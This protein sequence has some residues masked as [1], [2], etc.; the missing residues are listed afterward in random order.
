MTGNGN[1]VR[2]VT[3]RIDVGNM[4]AHILDAGRKHAV[5][6]VSMPR[7]ASTP[8]VDVDRLAVVLAHAA[9]VW[10]LPTGDLSW[11][12]TGRLPPG[13]DVYGGATRVWWPGMSAASDP[14]EQPLLLAHDRS[15]GE[16]VVA[17]VVSLFR[18]R[19]L[20]A[21][22][23]D[24][25]AD[26]GAET[27]AVVSAIRP[28]GAELTLADGRPA[29][30]ATR[31]LCDA[32]LSADR[33]V[34]VGQ[35]VRVVVRG[36]RMDD[37]RIQVTLRPFQPDPWAR[38]AEEY[39]PGMLI[40][41]IVDELRRAGAFVTLL[42]G[43]RGLLRRSQL[44][45]EWV[46][47]PEDY[48]VLGERIVARLMAL[49]ATNGRADL[50]WLD[51]P[52]DED[53]VDALA[54]YP[55]GPSWLP[56]IATEAGDE[57]DAYDSADEVQADEP[58]AEELSPAPPA[59]TAEP[60]VLAFTSQAAAVT[61]GSAETPELAVEREPSGDPASDELAALEAAV[62]EANLA[63]IELD[64]L[65]DHSQRRLAELRGDANQLRRELER[66]LVAAR[67][68]VLETAERDAAAMIGSTE[69]ALSGAREE[70][71]RLQ[72]LLSAAEAD[73]LELV[74]QVTRER[75][76]ANEADDRARRA[77]AEARRKDGAL[78]ELGGQL[79]AL[80]VSP[81][82][83]FLAEV[84][85]AWERSTTPD[86]RLRYPWREPTLGPDFLSSLAAVEGVAR[87]RVVR[88]CAHVCSGRA[89][90]VTGLELHPLRES[91]GGDAPQR[92][93]EDGAK[94]WR[95]SLQADTPAARRLH[96]WQ[97]PDAGVELANVAYHDD[98]TI[99]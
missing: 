77:R 95:C 49:D 39:E 61:G 41:G 6:C 55:D 74:E 97:L 11:D 9:E 16:A 80:G 79:D 18:E 25:V 32:R 38:I 40:E 28:G 1:D 2:R 59:P 87:D 81:E 34:R 76:R 91:A 58:Q 72:A 22:E 93:R 48:L 92:I 84:R 26:I 46:S 15:G 7:W 10:L 4:A 86:D 5:V 62:A 90:D 60:D 83:I 88:A 82:E 8:F 14:F 21:D 17:Q 52:E 98:L 63:R 85:Q 64:T 69:H 3:S 56:P 45:T 47:H 43:A 66:D 23:A 53:P 70:V 29:F 73:R 33:V 27:G 65:L 57:P 12:L 96:Y 54:L 44:S 94:A 19:G 42:P 36:R 35:A 68:R 31:E 24:D 37:S 71:A 30:A 50:S 51:V 67:V 89:P 75:E 78:E 99:R 13:L 20:L